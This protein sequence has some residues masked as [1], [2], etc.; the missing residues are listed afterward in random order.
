VKAGIEFQ[1]EIFRY[2]VCLAMGV[3][4]GRWRWWRNAGWGCL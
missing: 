3:K 2:Y 1:N 4:P